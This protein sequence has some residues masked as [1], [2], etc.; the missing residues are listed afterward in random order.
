MTLTL[1]LRIIDNFFRHP[2]R[3]LVP[4]VLLGA[5]GLSTG[6][7]EKSYAST[8]SVFVEENTFLAT[9]TGVRDQN[10]SYQGANQVAIDQLRGLLSTVSFTSAVLDRASGET[11][12]SPYPATV[13]DET[14]SA[15]GLNADRGSFM[16]ITATTSSPGSAQALASAVLEEYVQWQIGSDV[17][18]SNVAEEFFGALAASYK[19]ELDQAEAVRAAFLLE[20]PDPATGERNTNE[21]LRL[22]ELDSA[23]EDARLQYTDALSKQ[24]EAL[25]ATTQTETDIRQGFLVVDNPSLPS[26]PVSGLQDTIVRVLLFSMIGIA[27]T[28]GVLLTT[29]LIDTTIRFPIEARERLGVEVLAVVPRVTR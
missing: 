18:Q 10:F 15:I 17:E 28:A 9:L 2:I 11:S 24:R 14:R 6:S 26:S 29:T 21:T 13:L 4:I 22:T 25:L 16:V 5:I 23:V 20:N 19:I 27:A 7:A 3:Y 8:G 1:L 12:G